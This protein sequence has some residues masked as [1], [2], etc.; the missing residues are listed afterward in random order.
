[1]SADQQPTVIDTHV[2]NR[3]R[4]RRS[5]LRISQEKLGEHLG[6][7]F[8]QIQKYEKG[9]NRIGAG[10]LFQ[11]AKFLKVD[12][13]YFYEGLPAAKAADSGFSERQS[14]MP[15]AG[16]EDT[17]DGIALNRAFARIKSSK[18]RRKLIDLVTTI[19]DSDRS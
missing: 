3:I 2:G 8:Q 7:S 15:T 18:L 1:M 12:P 11:I 19:A 5:F 14:D 10:Q 9:S 4:L 17:T 6:V 13:A 16:I